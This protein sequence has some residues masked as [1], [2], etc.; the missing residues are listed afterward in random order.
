[1]AEI[2]KMPKQGLQMT[3]G[4]ILKW[5]VTEGAQIRE[6]EPFFEVETDKLT[7]V[8]D[9]H[10]TGTVLKLLAGVGDAV[11]VM[12][13]IAIIGNAGEDISELLPKSPILPEKITETVPVVESVTS[14]SRE[15]RFS[16]DSGERI[17]NGKFVTPRARKIARETDISIADIAKSFTGS[18]ISSRDVL[19]FAETEKARIK[20]S[21]VAQRLADEKGIDLAS[22]KKD[23][24]RIMKADVSAALMRGTLSRRGE[25]LVPFTGM[26]KVIASRMLE[27]Q[28]EMAQT[29]NRIRVDVSELVALREKLAEGGI[30]VSYNDILVRLVSRV[31]PEFPY[32]NASWTEGGILL[33]EYVNMGIAV[34]LDEGLVVPVLRDADMLTLAQIAEQGG[35]LVQAAREGSLNPDD[36]SEGTFTLSNLGMFDTEEF[37][38]IV[39]PP[40][41]AILAV[42]SIIRQ[43]VADDAGDVVVKP[44]MTLTLSYDHRIVDGAVAAKFLQRLKQIIRNPLLVY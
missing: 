12:N 8:V 39:N 37:V 31:L 21:P 29:H 3:E 34:G 15:T 11:P 27:S 4:T 25:R 20:A 16:G 18:K 33:H 43:P 23:G 5:F 9:S 42:G 19:A 10:N 26:R 7:L 22:V 13:P 14:S 35:A 32:V 44:M 38:A 24:A 1:M 41:A 2:V 28:S 40:Q 30:K 6:G 17:L 36:F